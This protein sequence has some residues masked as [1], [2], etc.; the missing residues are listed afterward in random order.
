MSQLLLDQVEKHRRE[1]KHE[2][3]SYALSEIIAMYKAVPKEIEIQPDWQRLF[4]W[5]REQQS[6]FIESLILEVPI[7]P[8]FFFEAPDGRWE[9]LD[10]L[11]RVSTIL[12]FMGNDTDVPLEYQGLHHNDDEWHEETR[13][14]ITQPLQ[15]EKPEYL[16]ALE[17]LGYAR[18]PTSL[19][20]NLKRSR[21]QIYV[22][23]RETDRVYKYEV[24]K[25][26]NRGGSVLE[27]QELR[28]CAIRIIDSKFPDFLKELANNE[29][30]RLAVNQSGESIQAAYLDELALR[31]LTMK[32]YGRQFKHDVAELLTQY[33]EAV[34]NGR[35]GFD[36]EK[37]ESL[38]RRTWTTLAKAFPDGTAFTARRQDG[39]LAGPFSPTL[40]EIISLAVAW[41]IDDAEG[42]S[43]EQIGDSLRAL[44]ETVRKNNLMGAGSNSRKKTLGRLDA[45]MQWSVSKS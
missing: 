27:E 12:K 44:I 6:A 2:V 36:F 15:L 32:N 43:S 31:F 9:L 13:N 35:I 33:M 22:L 39:K 37:E 29:D 28:N 25:R 40:F 5:T 4:R 16:T 10:G 30:F 23:K 42:C 8:L 38:F 1:I 3:L 45:A 41:H 26:L 24:F 20:L 21:L 18:F 11:Q 34:A 17:G 14:D 7:P 19:K